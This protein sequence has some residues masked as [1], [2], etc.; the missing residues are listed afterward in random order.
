MPASTAS[1][2]SHELRERDAVAL[3][4]AALNEFDLS[5]LGSEE[6]LALI[7]PPR[8]VRLGM[9]LRTPKLADLEDRIMEIADEADVDD[10]D[11]ESHFEKVIDAI[12][13]LEDME[14][15]SDGSY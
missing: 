9:R 12:N 6:M 10:D 14:I 8:L 13:R 4:D 7:P 11:P 5:F 1:A 15:D 2:C 3:E